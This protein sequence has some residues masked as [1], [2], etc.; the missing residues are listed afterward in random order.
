MLVSGAGRITDM[1]HSFPV[2]DDH[3]EKMIFDGIFHKQRKEEK[4]Y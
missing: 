2:Y 1:S 3:L 4:W